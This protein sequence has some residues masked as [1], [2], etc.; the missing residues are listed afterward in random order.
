MILLYIIKI[1]H[2]NQRLWP[3]HGFSAYVHCDLDIGDMILAQRHGTPLGHGQQLCEI[4]CRSIPTARSYGPALSLG[5][6]AL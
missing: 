5:M 2:G 4:L 3:G 6:C 1:K